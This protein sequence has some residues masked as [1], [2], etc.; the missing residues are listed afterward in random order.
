MS[1]SVRG[2]KVFNLIFH[3]AE[4]KDELPGM[5]SSLLVSCL[6]DQRTGLV[7]RLVGPVYL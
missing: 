2:G 1:Q 3:C 6:H 4:V 7:L 5:E